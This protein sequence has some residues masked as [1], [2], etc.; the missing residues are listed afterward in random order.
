MS[1][2]GPRSDLKLT[3]TNDKAQIMSCIEGIEISKHFNLLTKIWKMDFHNFS[4][5]LKSQH[6]L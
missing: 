4:L 6:C 3:V 1:M 5:Q 2:A